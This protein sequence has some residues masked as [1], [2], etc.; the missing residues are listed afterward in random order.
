MNAIPIS[1]AKK[2]TVPLTLGNR[3]YELS[4]TLNCMEAIQKDFGSL[5]DVY[6]ALGKLDQVKHLIVILVNEAIDNH[7]DDS[8]EKWSYVD[9]RYVGRKVS[10]DDINSL[11]V[12]ISKCFGVSLPEPE[13]TVGDDI[14]DEML[15]EL[16]EIPESEKN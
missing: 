7:N 14:P 16:T 13:K 15:E 12:V 1:T 6:D 11:A 10:A 5:G 4:L 8:D 9:E 2:E 3:T